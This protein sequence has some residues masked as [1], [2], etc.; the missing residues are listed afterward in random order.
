MPELA[1]LRL[2]HLAIPFANQNQCWSFRVLDEGHGCA[3][4]IDRGIVIHRGAEIR[5]HPLVDV[6]LTVIAQ[7]V[8]EA[9]AGNRR[10]ETMSL[11]YGPHRHISAVTPA[12]DAQAL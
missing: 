5:N 3:P 2:W 6:V 9:R 8:R 12:G 1:R 11:G 4:C 10:S 7:P